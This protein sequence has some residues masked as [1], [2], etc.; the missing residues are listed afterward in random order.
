MPSSDVPSGGFCRAASTRTAALQE[1]ICEHPF[2]VAL[3]AGSLDVERFGFY[4]T[5]DAR[6]L[7]GFSRVLALAAARAPDPES[8]SFF[9]L[10][11]HDA[12]AEE[13]SLNE[14]ELR[15]L[16][17]GPERVAAVPTSPT[18]FAYTSFLA[19][20]AVDEHWPVLMAALLPCFWVYHHVGMEIAD[21]TA[22]VADHPYRAWIDTYSDPAFGAQVTAIRRITDRAAALDTS[23]TVARMHEAFRRATEYE[24]MFWDSAWRLEA[25]PTAK[26]LGPA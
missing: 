11:A 1:A 6:F 16:G 4:L 9:A 3:A 15:R 25:W 10:A 22:D 19:A 8:A 17:W 13:R 21:Q 20:T 18:C 5:Q 12:L 24:W 2:K 26:W 23:A 14:G 7:R